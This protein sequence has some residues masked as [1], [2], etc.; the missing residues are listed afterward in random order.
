MAG[1]PKVKITF[2]A[3]F[4]DLKKGIKGGQAEVESFAS[5]VGDFG[6]KAAAAFAVAAVAA[7]AYAV[8]IGV[9]GV[10]AAL[11]DEKAQRILALTLENTTKATAGQIAQC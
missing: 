2:D 11:E 10:K 5:K 3:D 6:K 4:D 9:D 7:A 8:K 1:I